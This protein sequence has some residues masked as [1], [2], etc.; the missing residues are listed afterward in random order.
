M[1]ESYVIREYQ[2]F[3]C[4]EDLVDED[5]K[6]MDEKTFNSLEKFILENND[7]YES[8]GWE[9]FSIS[10]KRGAKVISA[11][12]YVGLITMNDGTTIEV[13]PKLNTL[14]YGKSR[15]LLRDMLRTAREL[16]YKS[17]NEANVMSD[18][19][20]LYEVFI[21]MFLQETG[22]LVKRG[23]KAGYIYH[24]SN[25]KYLKGKLLFNQ[26]LKDNIAHKE[27]F[28]IG[29]DEFAQNRPENKLIK[30]TLLYVK[31]KSKDWKNR[32][33]CNKYLTFFDE[34]DESDNYESDFA[35]CAVD[36]SISEYE[37]ILKWCRI[38]LMNKSFTMY[39]G[40]S[41]AFALL[42][43]MEQLFESYVAD[44]MKKK[45]G[46][47]YTV[48][49]QHRKYYLF[50]DPKK[51]AIRP[52]IVVKNRETGVTTVFDTKWKML[53][54]VK[55]DDYDVSSADMYQMYVYYKKYK[56]D[57]VVLVYPYNED[58]EGWER[59]LK[60]KAVEEDEKVN[61]QVRLID[62]LKKEEDILRLVE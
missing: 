39:K 55:E 18:K 36:R 48:S 1:A 28:Y 42:F 3:T 58:F 49:A 27:R 8:Q 26:N 43:P 29:Y 5:F 17:F 15:T 46:D 59:E 20:N 31:G 41:V 10:I 61:I 24:E 60:Y 56:P 12:N 34:I 16:P 51:F 45:L 37:T 19:M 23:L 62:L 44:V 47:E 32:T 54:P 33:D 35:K 7:M 52:D 6:L 25:E 38:F 14:D 30:S 13:L 22:S 11:R 53:T 57:K 40:S 4:R 2:S 9:F 21:R 50:D